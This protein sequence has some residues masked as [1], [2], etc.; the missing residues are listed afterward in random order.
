M[1]FG[2]VIAVVKSQI[3]EQPTKVEDCSVSKEFIASE[4][5]NFCPSWAKTEG[6]CTVASPM[7]PMP[8]WQMHL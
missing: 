6:S 8:L 7:M 1:L 2:P 4:N 5:Y 3:S